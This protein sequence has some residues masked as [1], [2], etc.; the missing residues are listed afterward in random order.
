VADA[1]TRQSPLASLDLPASAAVTLT[2]RPFLGKLVLRG[3]GETF[4]DAVRPVLGVDLPTP[5]RFAAADR[6]SILWQGPDSWLLTGDA[7]AIRRTAG[8][9]RAALAGVH[10]AVT[11]VSSGT[12]VLRLSGLAARDVLY[13]GCGL[14]LDPPA[15][16]TGTCAPTRVAAFAVTLVQVDGTPTYDMFVA[17]SLAWTFA[18]WLIDACREFKAS[19]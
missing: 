12:T 7:D 4:R 18:E 13:K 8:D 19:G 2:E 3:D 17:R 16:D 10:A 14:D 9:L 11:D 5:L 15:F 6:L 1:M